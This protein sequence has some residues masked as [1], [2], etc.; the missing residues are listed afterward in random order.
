MW[1][2]GLFWSECKLFVFEVLVL[3]QQTRQWLITCQHL[4][5]TDWIARS[6][7]PVSSSCKVSFQPIS[8]FSG[9]AFGMLSIAM[10]LNTNHPLRRKYLIWEV[11]G[12]Y[13][14]FITCLRGP[15]NSNPTNFWYHYL[16]KISLGI[17]FR[18]FGKVDLR[19][20]PYSCSWKWLITQLFPVEA[21]ESIIDI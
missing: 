10:R 9:R 7:K 16:K 15:S 3:S 4:W 11:W 1:I 17:S 8:I 14:V 20:M 6:L 19:N 5:H 2:C 12:I 13:E 18:S 21:I